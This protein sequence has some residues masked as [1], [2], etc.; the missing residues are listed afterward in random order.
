MVRLAMRDVRACM[1][2]WVLISLPAHVHAASN[3]DARPDD[4]QVREEA[5]RAKQLARGQSPP[6]LGSTLRRGGTLLIIAG[7][8]AVIAAGVLWENLQSTAD[9][10]ATAQFTRSLGRD[11]E[12]ARDQQTVAQILAGGGAALIGGGVVMYYVGTRRDRGHAVSVC[13]RLASYW[14]GLAI[15]GAF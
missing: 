12:G 4:T 7:A 9:E 5:R 1:L 10:L 11:V 2:L 6:I 14:W 3:L 13:P 15:Q 8:A